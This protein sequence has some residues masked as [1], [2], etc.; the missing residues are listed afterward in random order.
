MT[1]HARGRITIEQWGR[2][3]RPDGSVDLRIPA[4]MIEIVRKPA[5]NYPRVNG[6]LNL[7]FR[8]VFLREK[9]GTETDFVFTEKYMEYIGGAVW[10]IQF[11][12]GLNTW[13]GA[14]L[15]TECYTEWSKRR[16]ILNGSARVETLSDFLSFQRFLLVGVAIYTPKKPT[17]KKR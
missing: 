17:Q 9:E 8:D 10:T 11:P 13:P 3:Q 16:M 2:N 1:V 5:P 4:Q 12:E 6:Q 7:Q 14:Q 15:S